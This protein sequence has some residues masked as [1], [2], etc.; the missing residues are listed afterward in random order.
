MASELTFRP[1]EA[2]DQADCL[3][4]FDQNCP[5]FFAPK[6]RGDYLT[7]LATRTTCYEVCLLAGLVV[8]AFGVLPDEPQG[9]ALRWILLAP[10]MQGQGLGSAIM[11]R[12]LE[13][14]RLSGG[15][16][17]YIGASHR[18]AP[19]FAKFGARETR[20][21]VDGWGPGM[22]RVDMTLVP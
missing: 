9:L 1:Y 3:S 14:M 20:T 8:G 2:A 7:F 13:L 12:V 6:E 19:F 5:A 16:S 22:H 15:R 21:I 17:L 11:A 10:A 4:L 18:S